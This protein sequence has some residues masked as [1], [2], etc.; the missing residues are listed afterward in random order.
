MSRQQTR[1][2]AP[3]PCVSFEAIT[4]PSPMDLECA[5][6]C[7]IQNVETAAAMIADYRRASVNRAQ[8]EWQA[9]IESYR[10]KIAELEARLKTP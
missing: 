4:P 3:R 1:F 6:K 5:M 8:R 2:S 7:A 9:S 10:V